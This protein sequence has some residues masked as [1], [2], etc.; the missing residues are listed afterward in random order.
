[1]NKNQKS[2]LLALATCIGWGSIM[3]PW[4]G[5]D[6]LDLWFVVAWAMVASFALMATAWVMIWIVVVQHYRDAVSAPVPVRPRNRR[7]R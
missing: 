1:M 4:F 5:G 7:I 2:F 3:G 6:N